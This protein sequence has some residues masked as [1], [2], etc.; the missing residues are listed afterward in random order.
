M[1][2][3]EHVTAHVNSTVTWRPPSAANKEVRRT[4]LCSTVC[5]SC[6]V[7]PPDSVQFNVFYLNRKLKLEVCRSLPTVAACCRRPRSSTSWRSTQWV[8][9]CHRVVNSHA[10][11]VWHTFFLF[12]HALTPLIQF[13]TQKKSDLGPRLV[14]SFT[15]SPTV[16]GATVTLFAALDILLSDRRRVTRRQSREKLEKRIVEVNLSREY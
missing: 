5:T 11:G 14:C 4:G 13:L 12:S 10:F 3:N 8:S 9:S 7:Y 15:N 1:N 16:D 6:R 2:V